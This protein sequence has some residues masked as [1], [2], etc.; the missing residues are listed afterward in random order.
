MAVLIRG[1]SVTANSWRPLEG[2]ARHW[3]SVREDGLVPDFPA[4]GDLVVPLVVWQLRRDDLLLRQ[5]R[6][7]VRL[8]PH[9]DPAELA[10]DAARLA[11]VE[12]SFPKFGDGRGFSIARLLRGRY[13]YGGELR[14]V[15]QV[16][17]EHLHFMAQCG[18]DAF[19]LRDGEDAAE[20][21]AAFGEL[22]A[23]YHGRRAA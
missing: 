10:A 9:E 22:S 12:V 19:L 2:E 20:A 11:L 5:G 1:R 23:G 14:A 17:R 3:L 7:G 21:L 15:G 16:T 13:G 6:A 8:E 18:F 4:E